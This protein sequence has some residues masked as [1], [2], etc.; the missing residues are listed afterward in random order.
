MVDIEVCFMRKLGYGSIFLVLFSL[1]VVAHAQQM[2]ERKY[3]PPGPA[4]KVDRYL[5]KPTGSSDDAVDPSQEAASD[6]VKGDVTNVGK[7]GRGVSIASPTIQPGQRAP[8]EVVGVVKG[9]VINIEK[10][11]CEGVSIAAPT[12]QPGQRAPKEVVGVV[13]GDAI[14]V[15]KRR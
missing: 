5:A 15:C 8:R 11:A 14:N 13:R 6:V 10:G 12:I 1:N 4:A 9:D 3:I 7:G 2:N